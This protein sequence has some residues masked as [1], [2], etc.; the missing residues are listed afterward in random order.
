MEEQRLGSVTIWSLIMD[1]EVI[2]ELRM[3]TQ[4]HGKG[5][6]RRRLR[7]RRL[8]S[9]GVVG[10]SHEHVGHDVKILILERRG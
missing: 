4:C 5:A 1:R 10:G 3:T 6:C 9:H 7:W 2:C 8:E